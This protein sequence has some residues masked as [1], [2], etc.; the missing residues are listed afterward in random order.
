MLVSVGVIVSMIAPVHPFGRLVVISMVGHQIGSHLCKA[1]APSSGPYRRLSS[2]SA[3]A[4]HK[5]AL[6]GTASRGVATLSGH[7][8]LVG[9]Y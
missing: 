9:I 3:Y 6:L 4:G 5:V 7:A 1:I 8:E 2:M